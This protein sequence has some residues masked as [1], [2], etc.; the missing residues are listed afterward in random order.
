MILR[1][2]KVAFKLRGVVTIEAEK[3]ILFFSIKLKFTEDFFI[4]NHAIE[5]KEINFNNVAS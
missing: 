3:E 5:K 1:L 4:G 2:N